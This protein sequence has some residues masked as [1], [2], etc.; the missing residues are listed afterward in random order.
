MLKESVQFLE[1]RKS[2]YEIIVVD[3]GS[4]VLA[5]YPNI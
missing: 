3:D 4:K 2:T 1:G 5:F